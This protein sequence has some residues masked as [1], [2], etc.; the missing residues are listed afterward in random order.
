MV[1]TSELSKWDHQGSLW[2]SVAPCAVIALTHWTSLFHGE[3]DIPLLNTS[4]LVCCVC[5]LQVELC[6][7]LHC[8]C[9][10][11][12][13]DTISAESFEV[14]CTTVGCK[15][16]FFASMTRTSCSIL[17]RQNLDASNELI[18]W[19]ASKMIVSDGAGVFAQ[20]HW[21]VESADVDCYCY[22]QKFG[23]WVQV[24]NIYVFLWKQSNSS[25]C[26]GTYDSV[27]NGTVNAS[28]HE[29]ETNFLLFLHILIF[30]CR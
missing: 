4:C 12:A 23:I 15:N 18:L 11:N 6:L 13:S 5:T 3:N 27:S 24:K 9:T 14:S 7:V 26:K 10:A 22:R 19:Y 28:P 1:D 2:V 17:G 30:Y 8:V 16:V 21:R 25:L 29:Q 20:F